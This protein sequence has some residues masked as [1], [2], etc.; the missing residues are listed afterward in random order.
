ML[1]MAEI[2]RGHVV[3]IRSLINRQR[4][5]IFGPKVVRELSHIEAYDNPTVCLD[6]SSGDLW[7]HLRTHHRR[8]KCTLLI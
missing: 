3:G 2:S 5:L 8:C 4:K 6:P 1:V 7:R